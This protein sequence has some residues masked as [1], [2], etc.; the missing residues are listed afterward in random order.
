MFEQIQ[1]AIFTIVRE[2]SFLAHLPHDRKEKSSA[3]K[4]DWDSLTAKSRWEEHFWYSSLS[5]I[6]VITK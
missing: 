5:Q 6:L 1:Q 3:S 4:T 2:S